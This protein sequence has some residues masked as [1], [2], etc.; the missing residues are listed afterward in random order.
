ME[1]YHSGESVKYPNIVMC[2]SGE[3]T[4]NIISVVCVALESLQLRL[5]VWYVSLW[6]VYSK[7]ISMACVTLESLQ[8]RVL[9]WYVSL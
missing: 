4:A 6:R 2:C 1:T 9:V 8:P 3:F 5:L 7:I